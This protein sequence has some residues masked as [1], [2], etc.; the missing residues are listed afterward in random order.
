MKETQ[1]LLAA[2]SK[3]NETR[4]NKKNEIVGLEYQMQKYTK[5]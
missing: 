4:R 5:Y 2:N 1:I 3:R